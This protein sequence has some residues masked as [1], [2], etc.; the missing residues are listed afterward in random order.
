M[1]TNLPPPGGTTTRQQV[2]H[3]PNREE[4]ETMNGTRRIQ[5]GQKTL[6]ASINKE[7]IAMIKKITETIVANEP[8]RQ[9]II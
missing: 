7:I 3:K 5:P 4:R 9:T 1:K 8:V 6:P 2:R